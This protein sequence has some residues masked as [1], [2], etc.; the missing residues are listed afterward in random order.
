[1]IVKP[2]CA[3]N[4]HI[5]KSF[6]LS[7]CLSTGR[8]ESEKAEAVKEKGIRSEEMRTIQ[9]QGKSIACG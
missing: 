2:K 8:K 1:M 7:V 4:L 5:Q 3:E 9:P 6:T